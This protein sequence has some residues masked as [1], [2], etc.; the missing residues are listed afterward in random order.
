MS[1]ALK[2]HAYD[3]VSMLIEHGANREING[4]S[5]FEVGLEEHNLEIVKACIEKGDDL[6][7]PIHVHYL[8]YTTILLIKH[9]FALHARKDQMTLH[10]TS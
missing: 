1:L 7:K 10:H 3:I 9:H 4:Q 2:Y 8:L 5:V 6:N